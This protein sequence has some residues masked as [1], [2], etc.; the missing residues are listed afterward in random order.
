[1]EQLLTVAD[2]QEVATLTQAIA[3]FVTVGM[4]ARNLSARTRVE[5]QNDLTDLAVYLAKGGTI[6]V[7]NIGLTDL[8]SYQAE[9]DR[10]GF[11][12]STRERKTY[13][14][15]TFFKFLHH[16]GITREHIASRLIPPRTEKRE[17]RFLSEQEYQQLLRAASHNTRDATIIELFLQTGMRLSELSRLIR[18]DVEIPKRITRDPDNTGLVRILRKRGKTQ[19][20]PLNYKA[21]QAVASYLRV[22]PS[23]EHDTLFVT[24]FKTPMSKRAVQ[25]TITKY[26]QEVGITHASTHTLRHTMATH[27]VAR[28]TDIKTLQETLGHERL[29]TTAIYVSLA[30][31]AQRKALQEHAL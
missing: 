1:M 7:S 31:T 26:L 30:K 10:R 23:V 19:T 9:M 22:R 21:C 11:A 3:Y 13:A 20:I 25:Y 12:P 5:Y 28:G 16:Q 8:E 6:A 27:H 14:I 15:K 4:P 18:S 2:I 29:E 24:K 17:P